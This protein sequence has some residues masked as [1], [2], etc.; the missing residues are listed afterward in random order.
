MQAK[1]DGKRVVEQDWTYARLKP[2][3]VQVQRSERG[4]RSRA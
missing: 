4:V 2:R 3:M 1:L